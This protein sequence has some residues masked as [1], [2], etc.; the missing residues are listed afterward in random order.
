MSGKK[1]FLKKIS[2]DASFQSTFLV[3]DE[4]V[5]RHKLRVYCKDRQT[6]ADKLLPNYYYGDRTDS[7]WHVKL[8]H[9]QIKLCNDFLQKARSLPQQ[10]EQH[11]TFFTSVITPTDTL[12][13][14][15]ECEWGKLGYHR[16]EHELFKQ[17][18]KRLKRN[19]DALEDQ[20]TSTLNG[21]WYIT[22]LSDTGA[23]RLI[24][25]R[26]PSGSNKYCSWNFSSKYS[27]KSDC[28]TILPMPFSKKYRL[29]IDEGEIYLH[30]QAG[31]TL[32][33]DLEFIDEN[34]GADFVIESYS[35]TEVILLLLWKRV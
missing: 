7:V 34:P 21:R 11:F 28:S 25:H 9:K 31:G 6:W 4:D 32:T 14:Q 20:L 3:G 35:K 24:L 30:I 10:C 29:D 15:G 19:R 23:D 1:I 12:I 16:V 18:F 8:N 17:S 22:V 13:I 26:L 5:I 27:F 2:L 33:K